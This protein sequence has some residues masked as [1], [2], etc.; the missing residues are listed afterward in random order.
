MSKK[1]YLQLDPEL[2]L[3]VKRPRG[4]LKQL[5]IHNV[6]HKVSG[7]TIRL[8]FDSIPEVDHPIWDTL[9]RIEIMYPKHTYLELCP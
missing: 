5:E 3:R 9:R 8:D 7:N 6:P 1:T 4:L 2:V